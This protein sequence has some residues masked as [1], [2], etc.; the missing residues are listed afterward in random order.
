MAIKSLECRLN[1]K[2]VNILFEGL[3]D[4]PNQYNNFMQN[5]LGVWKTLVDL[6]YS[7]GVEV[8][9]RE[10]KLAYDLISYVMLVTVNID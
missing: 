8:E 2:L 1:I 3:I 4:K 7:L 10:R 5:Y 9:R 6:L